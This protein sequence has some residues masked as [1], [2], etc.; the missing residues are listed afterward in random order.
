MWEEKEVLQFV[1]YD[2]IVESQLKSWLSKVQKRIIMKK[3]KLKSVLLRAQSI[4]LL[5][6][7]FFETSFTVENI[8]NLI[9]LIII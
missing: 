3:K 8:S 1:T 2:F 5:Y 7:L 9:S 6:H 4:Y